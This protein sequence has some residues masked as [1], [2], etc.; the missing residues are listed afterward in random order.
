MPREA[1]D[2]T[3]ATPTSRS[4]PKSGKM[5]RTVMGYSQYVQSITARVGNIGNQQGG[6]RSGAIWRMAETGEA[7]IKWPNNS[8]NRMNT[9]NCT[10]SNSAYHSFSSLAWL[11]YASQFS[12]GF[13]DSLFCPPY[14][15][16]YNYSCLIVAHDKE[17]DG[18]IKS[19]II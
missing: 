9:A 10:L 19:F 17:T 8:H 11:T 12:L 5:W 3:F 6:P 2:P 14:S 7:I 18:M 1:E 15:S 4:G 16:V 13:T